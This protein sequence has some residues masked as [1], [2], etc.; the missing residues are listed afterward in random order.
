MIGLIIA[1]SIIGSLLVA[2]IVFGSIKIY[3]MEKN[4]STLAECLVAYMTNPESVDIVE[5]NFSCGSNRDFN[6]PNSTGF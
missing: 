4:M 6:F 1:T 3:K 5:S 2:A